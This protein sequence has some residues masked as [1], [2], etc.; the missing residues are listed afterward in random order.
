MGRVAQRHSTR[1]NG[2]TSKIFDVPVAARN[3]VSTF[4]SM[5]IL[6]SCHTMTAAKY[7]ALMR[8]PVEV[9]T[10]FRSVGASRNGHQGLCQSIGAPNRLASSF[11]NPDK[12][13]KDERCEMRDKICIPHATAKDP[14]P[15]TPIAPNRYTKLYCAVQYYIFTSQRVHPRPMFFSEPETI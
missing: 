14:C 13:L 5:V 4:A 2:G 6:D 1:S 15:V 7:G 8:G 10:Y 11:C 9:Q 3:N 12:K